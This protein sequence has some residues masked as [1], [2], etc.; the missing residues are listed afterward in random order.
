MKE[1]IVLSGF[2]IVVVNKGFVYVGDAE[3]NKNFCVISN[4]MC[5]RKWG[6]TKGL[7]ELAINGNNDK[8]ILDATGT[9]R[10]PLTSLI[11]TIDTERSKWNY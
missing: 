11:Q 7:G 2:C 9:V 10:I 8:T 5:I 1:E 3:I 6:A 4:A